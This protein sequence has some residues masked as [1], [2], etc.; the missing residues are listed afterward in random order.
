MVGVAVVWADKFVPFVI[1]LKV[2]CVSFF[3]PKNSTSLVVLIEF[4][5]IDVEATSTSL[6][7]TFTVYE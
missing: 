3:R 5:V 6:L 1:T 2:Y 4:A 7:K